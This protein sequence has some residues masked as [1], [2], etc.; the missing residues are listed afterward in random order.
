MVAVPMVRS[1]NTPISDIR[2]GKRLREEM[3]DLYELA[4]SIDRLGLLHPIVVDRDFRLVAGARRLKACKILGH[5][6][7]PTRDF[8][9]LTRD[10]RLEIELEENT[11][12]KDLTPHEI[13]KARRKEVEVTKKVLRNGGA[14]RNGVSRQ[15]VAKLGRPKE[16]ASE[17][18]V[19][20]RTGI[21]GPQQRRD[22]RHERIA[23]AHPF[24]QDAW[25]KQS[26]VLQA[27]EVLDGLSKANQKRVS[28]MIADQTL[29]IE[30]KVT[31]KLI[32]SIAL[33]SPESRKVIFDLHNSDR[34][35][36]RANAFALA[37]DEPLQPDECAL[38][39]TIAIK[40]L[41]HGL[42]S[43]PRS[44]IQKVQ[45][46]IQLLEAMRLELKKDRKL[47]NQKLNAKIGARK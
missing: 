13:M 5:E 39:Y 23:D 18:A 28:G 20:K 24:M 3:G 37:V 1:R 29:P 42:K 33:M 25:W 46:H 35:D 4:A 7:I 11:Q 47:C 17:R 40:A 14:K 2:F 22:T 6:K 36:D 10:E 44:K 32:G 9:D 12:R 16:V 43:A 38:Q 45:K 26:Q 15:V 27:G 34:A 30:P 19:Q 41:K 21:S 31:I 8:G